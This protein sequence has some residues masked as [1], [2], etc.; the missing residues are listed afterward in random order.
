M[1]PGRICFSPAFGAIRVHHH[2]GAVAQLGARLDGIEEVE[3]S[4]PFGSTKFRSQRAN[5]RPCITCIFCRARALADTT[6]GRQSTSALALPTITPITRDLLRTEDHGHWCTPKRT[7][8]AGKLC[9]ASGRSKDGKTAVL[10][11]A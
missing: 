5:L 4:N 1:Q 9:G 6:S 11:R 8:L 2:G 10:L 3:G 7:Q